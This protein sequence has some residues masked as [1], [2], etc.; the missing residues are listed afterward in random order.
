MNETGC[1]LPHGSLRS[2]VTP[3]EF[4]A[5]RCGG[6]LQSHILIREW[7]H[8]ITDAERL[9]LLLHELGHYLGAVHSPEPDSIMR[10]RLG[11]RL[12]R[13]RNFLIRFD[14]VN[15]LA[16][17]LV[18]EEVRWRNIEQFSQL[19]G[20]TKIRLRQIFTELQAWFKSG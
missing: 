9:E 15:T 1:F 7:S 5:C 19:T 18:A 13:N 12:A 4:R 6:A 17:Y 8:Y 2:A 14:P 3:P 20:P 16:I 10:K 11:D